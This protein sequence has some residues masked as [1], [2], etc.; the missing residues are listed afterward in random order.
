[1]NVKER[2][3]PIYI[4]KLEALLRRLPANHP[5]RAEIESSLA[6]SQA[7]YNGEKALDYFLSFLPDKNNFILHDLRLPH[8][9]NYFQLDV[10]L[11][12]PSFILIVEVKNMAGTLFFDPDFRQLVRISNGNEEGFPDPLSQ[13]ERQRFQLNEWMRKNKLPLLPIEYVVTFTNPYTVIK[14]SKHHKTA[15]QRVIHS[16]RLIS[17]ITELK[18]K[19]KSEVVKTA[20]LL[21]ICSKL[22]KQH[23]PYNPDILQRFKISA[24]DLLR[25]IHCPQ[26]DTLTIKRIRRKWLCTTCGHYSKDAHYSALIDYLLLIGPTISNK[27]FREFANID[28]SSTSSKLLRSTGLPATGTTKDTR[29]QLSYLPNSEK[30][31]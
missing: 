15:L 17:M 2:T 9:T 13:V 19:Y 16:E 10:L 8:N 12:C 6:K 28:S 22:L 11:L 26:C 20:D 14:T 21:K 4:L 1:M 30:N 18:S 25:G 29:Y 23:S 27:Q 5:K 7:G 24:D 3:T 31:S